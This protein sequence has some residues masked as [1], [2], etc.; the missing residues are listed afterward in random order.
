[1]DKVFCSSVGSDVA[2]KKSSF[3]KASREMQATFFSDFLGIGNI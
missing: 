2:E 1:M 3:S